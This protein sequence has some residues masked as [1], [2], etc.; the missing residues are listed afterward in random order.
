MVYVEW[1]KM[2]PSWRMGS[3]GQQIQHLASS[4]FPRTAGRGPETLSPSG[5]L[6]R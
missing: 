4:D 3:A 5:R 2:Q 1:A 6:I